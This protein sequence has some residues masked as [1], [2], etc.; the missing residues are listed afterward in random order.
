M[1]NFQPCSTSEQCIHGEL[2]IPR[3]GWRFNITVTHGLHTIED[4]R[5]LWKELRSIH[6]YQQGPWMVM[7]DFNTIRTMD[8]TQGGNSVQAMEVKDVNEVIAATSM[9]EL[10]TVGRWFTWTNEHKFSKIYW[11]LGNTTWMMFT[12]N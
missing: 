2:D 6:A 9:K 4:R 11:A 12:P 8:D 7:G 3:V 10:R 5:S 1:V